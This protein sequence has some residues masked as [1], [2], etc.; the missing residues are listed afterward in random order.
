MIGQNNI[1]L[2]E[3]WAEDPESYLSV[4]TPDFPNYFMVSYSRPGRKLKSKH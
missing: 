4:M 2:R 1:N 3:K